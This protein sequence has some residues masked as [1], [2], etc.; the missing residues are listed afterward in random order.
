LHSAQ[1]DFLSLPAALDSKRGIG[2]H[3]FP[4]YYWQKEQRKKKGRM[5]AGGKGRG[6]VEKK[7][8]G[9]V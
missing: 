8:E 3:P 4:L 9:K 7:D 5:K 2:W 6:R 1:S